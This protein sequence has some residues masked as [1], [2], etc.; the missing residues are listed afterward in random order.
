[1]RKRIFDIQENVILDPQHYHTVKEA[2]YAM[3]DQMEKDEI[4]RSDMVVVLNNLMSDLQF[5]IN[6]YLPKI[7][8]K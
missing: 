4:D 2:A 5:Y 7:V 6:F 3:L 1:M 8:V